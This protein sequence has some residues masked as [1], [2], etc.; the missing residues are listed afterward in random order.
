MTAPTSK[1]LFHCPDPWAPSAHGREMNWLAI[2]RWA[3]EVLPDCFCHHCAQSGPWT[4]ECEL[5]IPH[6]RTDDPDEEEQNWLE[7]ER[8]SVRLKAC[9]CQTE[10]EEMPPPQ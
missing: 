7:L 4:A 3:N 1:C 2:E 8:W 10:A 9:Y 5:H 6:P